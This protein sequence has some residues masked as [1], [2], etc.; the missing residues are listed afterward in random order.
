M[1]K[2]YSLALLIIIAFQ[3]V[4]IFYLVVK[5]FLKK[6]RV[7]VTK[8]QNDALIRRSG[9][10]LKYFSEP[11]PNSM[12]EDVVPWS[13]KKVVYT[14]NGDSLNEVRDYNIDRLSKFF[15]VVTLGDSYTFGQFINTKDNW[16]EILESKLNALN[17]KDIEGF[18]VINL[19]VED[20]DIQYSIERF[21]LRGQKYNPDL[22]IWFL[23]SDDFASINEQIKP[24]E[25]KIMKDNNLSYDSPKYLFD[26][27]IY[28]PIG[29]EAY[30]MFSQKHSEN[31][32][33]KTQEQF[34]SDFNK[35]YFGGLLFMTLN[36]S[37]VKHN[38][39]MEDIVKKRDQTFLK[40]VDVDNIKYRF[41]DSH[42]NELGNKK[43]A[44]DLLDYLR[45]YILVQCSI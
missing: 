1:N 18:E 42:P 30:E 36:D 6:P 17:C 5:I 27:N 29:Q 32:V 8:I 38:R 4:L 24:F 15:R 45:S 26:N 34:F 11:S 28:Y 13:K 16:T 25:N 43:I 10:K 19:G 20:Y 41:P 14:I 39:I 31:E 9:S 2:K 22:V 33:L 12:I 37:Y 7:I 40:I 21:I 35:Q 3:L 23:K 44:D